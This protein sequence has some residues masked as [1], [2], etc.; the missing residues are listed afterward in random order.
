VL[1][2]QPS[3]RSKDLAMIYQDNEFFNWFLMFSNQLNN[4][5][6][7]T[8]ADIPFMWKQKQYGK[9]AGIVAGVGISTISMMLLSG[10]RPGEDEDESFV[11]NYLQ[12]ASNMI[13]VIGKGISGGIEGYRK[14]GVEMFPVGGEA[15]NLLR[16]V[17]EH[18]GKGLDGALVSAMLAAGV[19]AGLPVTGLVK[20]PM[21]AIQERDVLEL[22]G[23]A[24][25]ED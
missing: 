14:G 3:A 25:A 1:E 23:P 21:E 5:W 2:T 16:E 11:L 15:G 24:F 17:L 4:I 10:W 7:M 22:F 9:M 12:S 6:N 8:T 18:D 20:R 19:T 13:P